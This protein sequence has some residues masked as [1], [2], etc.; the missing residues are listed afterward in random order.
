V[1]GKDFRAIL[2]SQALD[3]IPVKAKAPHKLG[4]AELFCDWSDTQGYSTGAQELINQTFSQNN[5]LYT[6][7][8]RA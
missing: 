4:I 6:I 1:N 8:Q 3:G 7:E 5:P 2:P